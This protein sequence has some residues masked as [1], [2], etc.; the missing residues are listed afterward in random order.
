[1][2]DAHSNIQRMSSF[3]ADYSGFHVLIDARENFPFVERRGLQIKAGHLNQIALSA[4][5]IDADRSI[6]S[7][8][9]KK[10]KCRFSDERAKL[11]IHKSYSQVNCHLEN[12]IIYAHN[13]MSLN[14]SVGP[15]T[16]WYLPRRPTVSIVCD[17]WSSERFEQ[18]MS[19]AKS[20]SEVDCLPDCQRNLYHL[21]LSTAVFSRCDERN[22]GLSELC[23]LKLDCD[24]ERPN[25]FGHQ[26]FE[27]YN[28]TLKKNPDYIKCLRS[29][30]REVSEDLLQRGTFN[31]SKIISYDAFEKDISMLQVF[32]D[33][34][35]V[36]KFETVPRLNWVNFISNIGGLMGL[37]LGF[38]VFTLIEV[39]SLMF[40][41]F[42]YV[43]KINQ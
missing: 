43:L 24:S 6:Y 42:K 38:N 13:K 11:V 21:K 18:L 10:R 4:T 16:P 22:L 35:A 33:S 23:D 2:L 32:F 8:E 9:P 34:V 27:E 12:E 20:K 30:I 41:I 3:E 25:M 39:I 15:C 17:P 28:K 26:V 36:I 14:N 1:M 19:L 29:N 31:S 37:C 7:V 5:R 40:E